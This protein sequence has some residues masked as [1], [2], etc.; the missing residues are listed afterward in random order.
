MKLTEPVVLTTSA[1]TL[2]TVPDYCKITTIK[3]LIVCNVSTSSTVTLYY[4][5]ADGTASNS[6]AVMKT[7]A[8][9]GNVTS[10]LTLNSDLEAGDSIQALAGH[11]DKL[12]VHLSGEEKIW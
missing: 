12:V 9:S 10:I 5:P 11:N 7:T 3:E 1:Q 4:V 8:I 6:N 2:Y